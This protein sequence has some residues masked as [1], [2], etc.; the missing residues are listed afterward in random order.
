M[1]NNLL[2]RFKK[3]SIGLVLAPGG[4][5]ISYQLG[6]LLA[7]KKHRLYDEVIAISSGSAGAFSAIFYTF[8]EL[9]DAINLY[10]KVTT[11]MILT[12]KTDLL[13]KIPLAGGALYSRVGLIKLINDNIQNL[14][15]Q[16]SDKLPIYVSLAQKIKEGRKKTYIPTYIKLND[17]A[18]KD[19]LALLLATTA[20]PGIF[21][22]VKFED[23]T[24]VDCVK[25]DDEPYAP[26][27]SYDF[28]MLFIIPLKDSHY[29]KDYSGL[30]KPIVDFGFDQ[31]MKQKNETILDFNTSN[32][33][34]NI[35][36][37]YQVA[38][39]ILKEM[40]KKKVLHKLTSKQLKSIEKS[41]YSLKTLNIDEDQIKSSNISLDDII[42]EVR[43][44]KTK[45]KK[46]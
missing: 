2:N 8:N 3:P 22:E 30:S 40:K 34:P 13:S 6:V 28:D 29:S 36:L 4:A 33:E 38:D 17:Y 5:R 41:I 25:A 19:I 24:Y 12:P 44:G 9:T 23:N 18:H 10:A 42:N 16:L 31:I 35:S 37:G 14:H 26:L 7:L 46:K 43:T 27:M 15:N 20:I 39:L 11:S 21:D 1:K 32:I 45:W